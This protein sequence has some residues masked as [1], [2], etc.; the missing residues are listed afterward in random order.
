MSTDPSALVFPI[1]L[2]NKRH[3]RCPNETLQNEHARSGFSEDGSSIATQVSQMKSRGPAATRFWSLPQNEHVMALF[4]GRCLNRRR[5][6][7]IPLAHSCAEGQRPIG[8]RLPE[9]SRD[10]VAEKDDDGKDV[11]EL[12]E[13]IHGFVCCLSARS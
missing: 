13:L 12:Q 11:N 1:L 3:R 7:A 10:D 6:A 2:V 8:V 5:T 9:K 4:S